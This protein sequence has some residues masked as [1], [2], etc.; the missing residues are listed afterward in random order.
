MNEFNQQEYRFTSKDGISSVI[1]GMIVGFF[2]AIILANIGLGNL[3]NFILSVGNRFPNLF[4]I[5]FLIIVPVLAILALWITYLIG[6]KLPFVYQFGK[7]AN[8]G[9]AN[10]FSDAGI[11]NLLVFLTGLGIE[12]GGYFL[13]FKS[14][15]VVTALINS[16]FWNRFWTF[17]SGGKEYSFAEIAQFLT[18]TGFSFAINIGIAYFVKGISPEAVDPKIW[19]NVAVVSGAGSAF[20]WNFLGYKFFVFKK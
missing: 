9:F 11:Y 12:R 14:A 18:V 8:V 19:S 4:F 20:I 1:L 6:K 17:K 7:F 15:G 3:P 2:S 10:F 5:S 13:F 16:F